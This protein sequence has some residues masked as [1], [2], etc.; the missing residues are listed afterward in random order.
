MSKK[1]LT[2]QIFKQLENNKFR[3][4]DN[5]LIE[6]GLNFICSGEEK[7]YILLTKEGRRWLFSDK[8]SKSYPIQIVTDEYILNYLNNQLEIKKRSV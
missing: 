2:F 8:L 3:E 4:R 6:E 5:V 7:E 1:L